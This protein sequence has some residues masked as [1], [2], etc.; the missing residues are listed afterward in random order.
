M[1]VTQRL[2]V[3]AHRS[4]IYRIAKEALIKIETGNEEIQYHISI[5]YNTVHKSKGM[6]WLLM[7]K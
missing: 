3:N 2:P 6:K 4:G 7:L 1:Y 5:Q